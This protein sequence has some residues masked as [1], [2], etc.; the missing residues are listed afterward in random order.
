MNITLKTRFERKL[1]KSKD[2]VE[3]I[4]RSVKYKNKIP[5]GRKIYIGTMWLKANNQ[6]TVDDIKYARNRHPYWKAVKLRNSDERNY[7]RRLLHDYSGGHRKF[8]TTEEVIYIAESKLVD[9]ELA[10]HFRVS[11]PS[12]QAKRRAI[13]AADKIGKFLNYSIEQTQEMYNRSDKYLMLELQK[14]IKKQ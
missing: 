7:N 8:W 12:I 10:Q 1:F 4:N 14:L 13:N 2:P 5:R 6:Y 3:Y 9:H 11:I